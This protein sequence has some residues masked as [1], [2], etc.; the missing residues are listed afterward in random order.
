MKL[1]T[2]DT[3]QLQQTP[4]P[5]PN[6]RDGA[7]NAVTVRPLASLRLSLLKMNAYRIQFKYLDTHSHSVIVTALICPVM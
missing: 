2:G 1:F 3:V 4:D 5:F 7:P 6:I